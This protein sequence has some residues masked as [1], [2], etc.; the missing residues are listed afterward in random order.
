MTYIA[1]ADPG[2]LALLDM[3]GAIVALIG[4]TG[5]L[6]R[7]AMGFITSFEKIFDKVA[8]RIAE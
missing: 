8:A 6:P 1:V 7:T 5:W 4:I 2:P 3:L